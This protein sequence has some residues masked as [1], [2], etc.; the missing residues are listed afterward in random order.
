MD[1]R[2]PSPASPISDAEPAPERANLYRYLPQN[3]AAEF[4]RR[5]LGWLYSFSLVILMLLTLAFV[6]V[7]PADVIMQTKG[8]SAM[9]VKLFIIIIS[10]A[11]FLF[12]SVVYYFSRLVHSRV[13]LNQ[14]PSKSVYL[15]LETRDLPRKSTDYITQNLCRCVGEIQARAGPLQNE[16]ERFDYP[17]MSPPSY[18]QQRNLRLG[19]L[20]ASLA[21]PENCVFED[22]VNSIGLKV[23]V[24]GLFA[25]NFTIPKHYTFREVL[26][27]I[28]EDLDTEGALDADL[29]TVLRVV[30]EDYERFKFGPDLIKQAE[31]VAFLSNLEKVMTRYI[32]SNSAE[33][34]R[35]DLA[36]LRRPSYADTYSVG[37]RGE[38]SDAESARSVVMTRP[39]SFLDPFDYHDD[40]ASLR[41]QA[42]FSNT[43][44]GLYPRRLLRSR[45]GFRNSRDSSRISREKARL[46]RE[47][48][49][50]SVGTGRASGR[51]NSA[52][53]AI[54]SRLGKT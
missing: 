7:T 32:N 21:L 43:G 35:I 29:A 1:R 28:A 12:A 4:S 11:F 47:K 49:G 10:N 30:V 36:S 50:S 37:S 17:G 48:S 40:A 23:K 46:S 19:F 3:L 25:G 2:P 53:S 5:V 9:G 38:P 31:L 41:R 22:V 18:I 52:W 44:F 51:R 39:L 45:D 6:V 14:I 34:T 24:D 27:A 20:H 42:L 13:L 16:L 26:L 15:P 54:K 8:T 33:F